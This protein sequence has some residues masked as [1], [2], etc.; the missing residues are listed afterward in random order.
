MASNLAERVLKVP[1]D[2]PAVMADELYVACFGR[3]PTP[4]E[5]TEVTNYLASR[6]SD[7]TQAVMELIW[8]CVNSA[9]FRFNH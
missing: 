3:T 5:V 9:E 7:R 2:Q 6:T 4:D 8:A 1:S